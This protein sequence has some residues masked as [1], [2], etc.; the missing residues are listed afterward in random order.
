LPNWASDMGAASWARLILKFII[1][2]PTVTCAIPATSRVD[3]VRENM[4]AATPPFLD[5]TLRQLLLD[6]VAQL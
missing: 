1:A 3:H 5:K 2:H 6:H 4:A